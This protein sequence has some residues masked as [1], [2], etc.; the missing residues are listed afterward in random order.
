MKKEYHY[1]KSH[2]FPKDYGMYEANII[3]RNHHN[4]QV[5]TQCEQWW[6]MVNTFSKRD[7]L[8]YSFTLWCQNIPFDFL[9]NPGAHRENDLYRVISH[10]SIEKQK[11]LY[12][13]LV[14]KI[15]SEFFHYLLTHEARLIH[16]LFDLL[17]KNK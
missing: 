9:C 10:K 16:R 6:L 12:Q 7:Q 4:K 8:S 17:L 3:L 14:G 1:L 13:R 5:I 2:G 15:E 11:N